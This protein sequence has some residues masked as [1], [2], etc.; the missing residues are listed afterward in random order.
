MVVAGCG[1]PTPT[2]N[3]TPATNQ[4]VTL[5]SLFMQQAGYS[6]QNIED[7]TKAFEKLHPNI[8]VNLT[9][10][11]YESLHDK[12]VTALATGGTGYDTV[13]TDT[14][15]APEFAKAG[16]L[17]NITND[18]PASV[19]S[20]AYQAAL[21]TVSYNGQYFGLPWIMDTKYFYYNQHMLQ[22]AGI[23][24]PPTTWN[25]VLS[26]AK[27]LKQKGIVKY[28]LDWSWSQNEALI[29]DYAALV[30]DFGGQIVNSN[31]K[32][33]VNQGGAMQALN[34]MVNSLKDGLS[35]PASTQSVEDDVRKVMSQGQAAFMLNW[36]YAYALENDKT[37]SKVAGQVDVEPLPGTSAVPY[38]A[39][40]VNGAMGL[41][42]AKNTKYPT[43]ALEYIEYLSSQQVEDKYAALSLPFYKSSL[44][45]QAVIN[46]APAMVKAA[47]VQFNDMVNRPS[48]VKYQTLSQILQVQIQKALLG[49]ESPQQAMNDAVSQWNSQ[50]SQ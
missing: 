18:I 21:N 28:P 19:K 36:T 15:W 40:S 41:A 27:I 8:K 12:I 30:A 49:Q 44:K 3:T 42:I 29:C 1:Q 50:Q 4:T 45:K 46:T 20:D 6:Q 47:S 25:Q 32:L 37:Q 13:L 5:N 31:G 24:S 43:Q 22:Q 35:N 33:V 34:F 26:D 11:P 9:F 17:M 48:V 23:T 7:M 10:V 39:P 14:I 38:P 2:N 16:F